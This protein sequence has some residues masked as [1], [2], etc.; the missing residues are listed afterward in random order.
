MTKAE[1]REAVERAME[2]YD[3]PVEKIEKVLCKNLLTK[4]SANY[5]AGSSKMRMG[6]NGNGKHIMSETRSKWSAFS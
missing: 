1:M 3:R 4:H 2:T 5:R 6:K